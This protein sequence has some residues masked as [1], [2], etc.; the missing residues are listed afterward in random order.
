M[1]R[2]HVLLHRDR[3]VLPVG[4][5]LDG[6]IAVLCG[7]RNFAVKLNTNLFH[8]LAAERAAHAK[9]AG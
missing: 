2:E 5:I 6:E 1:Q 7:W 9:T 3:R 8:L 4:E